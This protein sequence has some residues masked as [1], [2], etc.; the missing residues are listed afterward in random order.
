MGP[1]N[2]DT[3]YGEKATSHAGARG[4]RVEFGAGEILVEP[5][6]DDTLSAHLSAKRPGD[7][8]A[9]A[10]VADSR[11]G[12]RADEVFVEVPRAAKLIGRTPELLLLVQLPDGADVSVRTGSADLRCSG[13]PREV[14]IDSGSGDVSVSHASGTVD[15][16]TGS[17][18]ILLGQVSGDLRVRSGSG[19]VE[20]QYVG[21]DTSLTTGSGDVRITRLVGS[22]RIKTGSGDIVVRETDG[23]L[24]AASGSGDVRVERA[25]GGGV[26]AETASGDV[27]VGVPHGVSV[28]LDV[29]T[30]SGDI[31]SELEYTAPPTPDRP[32]LELRARTISGDIELL[33]S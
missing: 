17:G 10:L 13:A 27:R 12:V 1:V 3:G 4:L 24:T 16:K 8:G 26:L 31:A 20:I 32:T 22:A 19:D 23:D 30:V 28:W 18:D 15:T 29:H 14:R 21:G 6:T 33:H 11:V 2:T 9:E 25:G 7:S 5:S